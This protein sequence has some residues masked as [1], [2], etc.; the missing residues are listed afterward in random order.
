MQLWM[1]GTGNLPVVSGYQPDRFSGKR[2]RNG[3]VVPAPNRVGKLPTRTAR[4]AVPPNRHQF[5]QQHQHSCAAACG[6]LPHPALPRLLAECGVMK[7]NALL[8]PL[9][10]GGSIALHA[11]IPLKELW[12]QIDAA[13]GKPK[14]T[15]SEVTTTG[16]VAASFRQPNDR[17]VAFVLDPGEPALAV[18]ADAPTSA[19]LIPRNSVLLTGRWGEGPFGAAIE[20]KAVSVA[21]TNQRFGSAE[22]IGA[23]LFSDASSLA[24]RYVQLTNVTM[25]P[26]QFGVA[27]HA[28]ATDGTETKVQLLVGKGVE[29]REA[30]NG[31]VNVFG[32]PVKTD[33]GWK[34]VAARFLSA[35]GSQMQ[36]LAIQRTCF[37]CHSVDNKII[38]PAFRDVAA[39][40]RNDPD[41]ITKV[42]NQIQKGGGGKWG[43]IPMLP[44]GATVPPEERIA[45][46][47]WIMSYRWD[48]LLAE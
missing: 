4:L 20:L 29:G 40:Y 18:I 21:D 24:G 2:A 8:L 36:T 45:L 3:W 44:L 34:L 9:L 15:M 42:V 5:A 22:P 38:G 10:A 1:G 14:T 33:D 19:G 26:E 27:G 7:R 11:Q 13:T 46:A 41:A 35:R 23:A 48:F 47:E 32:I 16:I 6:D 28:E 31:P 43:P 17:V 39:K 37:T 30:P 25:K 12:L